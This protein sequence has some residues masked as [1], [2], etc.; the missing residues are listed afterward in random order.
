MAHREREKFEKKKFNNRKAMFI[1][2]FLFQ[3]AAYLVLCSSLSH[4]HSCSLGRK[5]R[6]SLGVP[7]SILPCFDSGTTGPRPKSPNSAQNNDSTPATCP[8]TKS[9]GLLFVIYKG[10]ALSCDR[11]F[12]QTESGWSIYYQSNHTSW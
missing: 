5:K 10:W 4:I 6:P 3:E 11:W 2:L 1:D 8:L 7:R 9:T 12:W